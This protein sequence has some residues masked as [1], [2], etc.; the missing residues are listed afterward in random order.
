MRG[1]MMDCETLGLR[2]DSV[3]LSIALIDF[4]LTASEPVLHRSAVLYPSMAAQYE[5]G[6]FADPRTVDWWTTVP[7]EAREWLHVKENDSPDKIAR[8]LHEFLP[9]GRSLWAHGTD[10]DPPLVQDYIADHRMGLGVPWTYNQV[11]DARTI[12]REL[13]VVRR[14]PEGMTFVKHKAYDD[15]LNQV[16]NLWE[17]WPGL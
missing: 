14:R 17:R 15:T 12:H 10:F 9:E 11:R 4:E 13:P 5:M 7:V 2:R 6:R 1:V 8:T 16:W 3:I